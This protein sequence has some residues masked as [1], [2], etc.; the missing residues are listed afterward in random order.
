MFFK[1][2]RNILF[3]L[4]LSGS[5]IYNFDP[6][7]EGYENLLVVEALLSDDDEAFEVGLSRSIPI[8]TGGLVPEANAQVSISDNIGNVFDLFEV[9]PGRYSTTPDFLSQT[10][11]FYQ[12]HIQ[13]ADGNQYESDTVLLRETPPIDSVFYKYEER[14]TT[15]RVENIPGLQIYLTTH[16]PNNNTW[17]YRWEFEETWE[18]RTKYNSTQI[19][20]DEML[21]EREEQINRCWKHAESAWILLATSKNLN[22]DIISEFPLI[23]ISNATDRLDTKYSILV[24]QYALSEKSFNYWKELEKINEN[25]G[26][27]FDPQPYQLTGNIHN[28]YD[29]NDIV[30]GFFD[31][32]SVQKERIFISRGEF[33]YFVT[34]NYYANCIDTVGGYGLIPEFILQGF[35]LVG[36]LPPMG[37][38]PPVYQFSSEFCIDCRIAGTNVKPD[39]WDY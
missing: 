31:A 4:L 10:G 34:P 25:L 3:L 22:E 8:N 33:Q 20:E 14:V 28:I 37:P 38:G 19:W 21:L 16:D 2:F 35:M 12:L 27:L 32:S 29:E 30:L 17:Y 6:P 13:T 23:Y 26:T 39:F 11:R 9:S 7:S 15:E 5:C 36:E 1:K 24:K 18:F